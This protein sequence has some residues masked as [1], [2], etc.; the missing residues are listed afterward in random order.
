MLTPKWTF[1]FPYIVAWAIASLWPWDQSLAQSSSGLQEVRLTELL[2]RA[3]SQH[4]LVLQSRSQAQVAG[5]EVS[6]AKWSRYPSLSSELRTDSSN[7]QSAVRLEQPLWSG[8]RIS[9]RIDLS[10]ASARSAEATAREAEINALT[11]VST[12]FFDALRLSE[13]VRSADESISEHQRLVELII[14]RQ[15]AEI[16]PQADVTL[17]RTRLQQATSERFQLQRQLQSTL[18]NLTQWVGP[19]TGQPAGPRH[20]DYQAPSSVQEVVDTVLGASAQ[21]QKLQA[22]IESGDAQ[23]RIAKAQG[24][25]TVVAGVQR[26]F[27]GPNQSAVNRH[28]AYVSLQFQP[29]AGLSASSGINAAQARLEAARHELRAFELSVDNQVRTLAS[30]IDTLQAQLQPTQELLLGMNSLVGSYLRQYQL[31]RKNWLDVLN[32]LREKNQAQSTLADVRYTLMLSQVRMLIITGRLTG[33]NTSMIH[34]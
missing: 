15:N 12:F 2:P 34:E 27:S 28:Q 13:K 8:G 7:A 20:I 30:D 22:Q 1:C 18:N 25:P 17:A 24:L 10:E 21:R 5:H 26:I 6:A 19:M 14:R 29:G 33:E 23:I 11:Q 9:G 31:G 32:V 3:V 16:S 4:P